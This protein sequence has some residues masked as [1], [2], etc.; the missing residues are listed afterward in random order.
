MNKID[1][2][3]KPRQSKK[4]FNFHIKQNWALFKLINSSFWRS[5]EKWF[6]A[7]IFTFFFIVI[8]GYINQAILI[9]SS[10]THTKFVPALAFKSSLTGLVALMVISTGLNSIP[11]S[12]MEIKESVLM[13]RIGSTPIKPWMFIATVT[14][15]YFLIM[16]GQILLTLFTIFLFF[17]F[18][19]FI[20]SGTAENPVLVT[21]NQLFFSGFN[22]DNGFVQTN[23]GGY[24]F[25]MTYTMLLSV[26]LAI[27][28]VSI[29]KKSAS[30]S[31]IGSMVYF[32][33]MFLSGMLFPLT[34]ISNNNLLYDLSFIS[35]FRYVN[36][37][38]T[39]AWSG[40]SIFD[41]N[42]IN[43]NISNDVLMIGIKNIAEVWTGYFVPLLFIVIALILSI[44]RF[45]WS[46]R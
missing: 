45:R 37:L 18:Q 11:I 44:Y 29:T 25:G 46:T 24:I 3:V 1:K 35:P 36:V 13:K 8:F 19:N 39:I 20:L 41:F 23:W 7:F 30:A 26:F 17:G 21:G 42:A 31:M 2:L 4:F 34:V 33:S 38:I 28:I 10:S 15:F 43:Q 16:I 6:M 9:T 40:I 12:I 27:L 32:L 14:F 5:V 22:I